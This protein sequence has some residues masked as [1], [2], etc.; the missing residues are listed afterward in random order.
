MSADQLRLVTG[1]RSSRWF[2][3]L[4]SLTGMAT[5]V[6]AMLGIREVQY[7]DGPVSFHDWL[8][9]AYQ[10]T[11]LF[12]LLS[13]P[14]VAMDLDASSP[15]GLQIGRWLAPATMLSAILWLVFA[16]FRT[17]AALL[18]L[19][20]RSPHLLII[21]FGDTAKLLL[22]AQPRAPRDRIVVLVDSVGDAESRFAREHRL[23][24]FV[25]DL[26]NPRNIAI[27]SATQPARLVLATDSDALNLAVADL[28]SRAQERS[29]GAM[30]CDVNVANDALRRSIAR[31]IAARGIDVTDLGKLSFREFCSALDIAALACVD[32]GRRVHCLVMGLTAQTLDLLPELMQ[33]AVAAGISQV[34]LTLTH[35]DPGELRRALGLSMPGLMI[36]AQIDCVRAPEDDPLA[37]LA[38][39]KEQSRRLG[40]VS[41]VLV[42]SDDEANN[43][44]TAISLHG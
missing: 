43:L 35:P 20:L 29:G 33:A 10:T 25:G 37:W 24:L 31:T 27:L 15:W 5:F 30:R 3:A 36:S 41:A 19:R 39:V 8:D 34:K 14:A 4:V 6:S 40:R 17:Q 16:W 12:G 18:W 44:A 7:S 38:L 22:S 13:P 32:G 1:A 42:A 9:I 26:E 11:G 28:V 23:T 2:W 21:G